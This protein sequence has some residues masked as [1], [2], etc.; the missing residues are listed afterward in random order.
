MHV[1]YIGES[2]YSAQ[3]IVVGELTPGGSGRMCSRSSHS[4]LSF[5]SSELS[6]DRF[7]TRHLSRPSLSSE[8][9]LFISGII[10]V[11]MP[12]ENLHQATL[13]TYL[14][15]MLLRDLFTPADNIEE[16][17]RLKIP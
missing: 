5:I 1:L 11:Y 3:A 15:Y 12:T 13:R 2:G 14:I 8:H 4:H 6:H 10:T 9:F 17:C 7:V 16:T